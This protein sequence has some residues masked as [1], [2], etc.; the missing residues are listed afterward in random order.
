MSDSASEKFSVLAAG[1]L[2]GYLIYRYAEEH[3]S[4]TIKRITPDKKTLFTF[5]PTIKSS[6]KE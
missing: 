5:L 1:S 4:K 6:C 3:E 2:S